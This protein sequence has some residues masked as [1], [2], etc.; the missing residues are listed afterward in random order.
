MQ[1]CVLK[2]YTYSKVYRLVST[3]FVVNVN[4][5][6]N[7]IPFFLYFLTKIWFSKYGSHSWALRF[8]FCLFFENIFTFSTFIQVNR[9]STSSLLKAAQVQKP[10]P[11][12]KAQESCEQVVLFNQ[13]THSWRDHM[14]FLLWV[15][16][17]KYRFFCFSL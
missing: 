7:Y 12:F 17:Q 16:Y 6:L 15:M 5:V 10:A 11:A 3:P 2:K 9:F 4:K 14:F 8:L 1:I 13:R